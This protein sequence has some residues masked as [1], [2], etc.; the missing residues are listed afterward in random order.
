MQNHANTDSSL[1]VKLLCEA[2]KMVR[3]LLGGKACTV[4]APMEACSHCGKLA[5]TS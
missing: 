2:G 3:G 4:E 1:P 5:V